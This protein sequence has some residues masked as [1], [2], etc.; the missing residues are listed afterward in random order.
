[1]RYNEL[2]EDD[3]EYGAQKVL[4]K[5]QTKEGIYKKKAKLYAPM[6]VQDCMEFLNASN[7]RVLYRGM[8]FDAMVARKAIRPDRNSKKTPPELQDVYNEVIAEKGLVANHSNAVACVSEHY[9]AFNHGKVYVFLP[10]GHFDITIE[11]SGL[12]SNFMDRVFTK[13]DP[14]K[15]KPLEVQWKK[16]FE[17]SLQSDLES[18]QSDVDY[19]T[20]RLDEL[21][22]KGIGDHNK[23]EVTSYQGEID[24]YTHRI[25]DATKNKKKKWLEYRKHKL[26]WDVP[27]EYK[28]LDKDAAKEQYEMCV[29][30][31]ADLGGDLGEIIRRGNFSNLWLKAVGA[32]YI[33]YDFW[34]YLE[35]EIHKLL[36]KQKRQKKLAA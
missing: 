33:E 1:M 21:K 5:G 30:S 27:R 11:T 35:G 24:Y 34:Q 20:K 25:E 4:P 22:A 32:Y 16:A 13:P 15:I 28:L 18:W 10:I 26:N 12:G 8:N 19:F 3:N 31:V 29:K 17:E 23:D 2:Y 14:K 7:W 36:K 6:I 9:Q